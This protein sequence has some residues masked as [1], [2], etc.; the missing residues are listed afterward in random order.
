[1]YKHITVTQYYWSI[2]WLL[3]SS[4]IYIPFASSES[5]ALNNLLIVVILKHFARKFMLL[6]IRPPIELPM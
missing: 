2:C 3:L 1:M 6:L 4:K 5:I